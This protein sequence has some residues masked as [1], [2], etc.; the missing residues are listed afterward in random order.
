M[1][2]HANSCLILMDRRISDSYEIHSQAYMGHM[3]HTFFL[4]AHVTGLF[5]FSHRYYSKFTTQ[6]TEAIHVVRLARKIDS[7]AA[8]LCIGLL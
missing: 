2:L 1:A 4:C 3:Q 6:N 8:M 5:R 7:K